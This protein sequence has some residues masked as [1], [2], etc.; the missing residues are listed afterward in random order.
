MWTKEAMAVVPPFSHRTVADN[1]NG[2]AV[3]EELLR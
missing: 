2:V 3:F 1:H